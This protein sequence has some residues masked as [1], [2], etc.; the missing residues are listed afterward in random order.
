V[1]RWYGELKYIEFDLSREGI[2]GMDLAKALDRLNSI[3]RRMAAFATPSYLMPR[4]F[5]LRHH[6][7]FVRLR[8]QGLRGR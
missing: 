6:I 7:D 1:A 3:E 8:L 4:W 5:T 2:S